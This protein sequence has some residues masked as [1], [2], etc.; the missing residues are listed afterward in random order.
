MMGGLTISDNSK[1]AMNWRKEGQTKLGIDGS[2]STK[3]EKMK[4]NHMI[5]L[6]EYTKFSKN[7]KIIPFIKKRSMNKTKTTPKLGQI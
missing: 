1:L 3:N 7:E 6:I 5:Y 4:I 2:T